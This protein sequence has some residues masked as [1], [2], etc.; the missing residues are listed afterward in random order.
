MADL[1]IFKTYAPA[2]PERYTTNDH[3]P[4]TDVFSEQ[5]LDAWAI[6]LIAGGMDCDEARAFIQ[7]NWATYEVSNEAGDTYFIQRV[8]AKRDSVID[9]CNAV[10]WNGGSGGIFITRDLELENPNTIGGQNLPAVCTPNPTIAVDGTW[11]RLTFEGF[12]GSDTTWFPLVEAVE[13]INVN[14]WFCQVSNC[15][16]GGNTINGGGQFLIPAV[17][18]PEPEAQQATTPI[19]GSALYLANHTFQFV[20][21]FGRV[22]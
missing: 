5:W 14:S 17:N 6:Q 2:T 7:A 8:I 15:C 1:S 3:R 11:G 13:T 9:L 10:D 21:N 18:M 20:R 16:G 22:K 4:R 12:V 19:L